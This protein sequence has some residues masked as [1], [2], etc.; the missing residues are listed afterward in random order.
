MAF[1]IN[2]FKE[3][4]HKKRNFGIQVLTKFWRNMTRV[5]FE[6]Q[7][8]NPPYYI[9][10]NGIN[11]QRYFALMQKN[12]VPYLSKKQNIPF[13]PVYVS[14]MTIFGPPWIRLFKA[15]TLKVKLVSGHCRF[16]TPDLSAGLCMRSLILA[17]SQKY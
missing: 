7:K 15:L 10:I 4:L 16:N 8:I 6:L 17:L 1:E 13:V 5:H 9:R 2:I 14:K 3:N 12:P 11:L